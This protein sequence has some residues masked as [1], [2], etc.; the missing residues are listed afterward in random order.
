MCATLLL[1]FI[2]GT[3]QVHIYVHITLMTP[4]RMEIRC[5]LM[6]LQS[7][8]IHNL[9]PK[10]LKIDAAASNCSRLK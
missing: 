7:P 10:A 1:Y 6:V 3:S 2:E 9:S 8:T 5:L 4:P